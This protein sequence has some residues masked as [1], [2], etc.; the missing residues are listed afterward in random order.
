MSASRDVLTTYYIVF[1]KHPRAPQEESE[2]RFKEVSEAYEALS[3]PEKRKV[4]DLYGEEGLKAG[5]SAEEGACVLRR[6]FGRGGRR[7]CV[8][9][10]SRRF[11]PAAGAH[12]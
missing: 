12:P 10:G 8:E 5:V 4:Y 11:P 2:K 6:R 1:D 9:P 3:D 7:A